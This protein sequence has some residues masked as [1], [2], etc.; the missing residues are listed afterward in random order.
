LY[1]IRFGYESG[2]I[3]NLRNKFLRFGKSP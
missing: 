3:T 1:D 2:K